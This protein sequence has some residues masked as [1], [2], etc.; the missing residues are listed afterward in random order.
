MKQRTL[1]SLSLTDLAIKGLQ[2]RK[3]I[4]ILRMDLRRI[5]SSITDY[6]VIC[7]GSSD[8]H[9]QALAESVVDTLREVGERPI[10]KEGI[11][12]G[13]WVVLDFV[14]IVVHIFLADKRTFYRLE[15]L[16]GDAAMD[17]VSEP[18]GVAAG[19]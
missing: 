5:D 3:G 15:S 8:R 1:S 14:S 18:V 13:E 19:A 12:R 9:V 11:Q 7:T 10:S 16:W 4:D 6:F 2:E 17:Y